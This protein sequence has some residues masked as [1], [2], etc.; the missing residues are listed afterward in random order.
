MLSLGSSAGH[1]RST[2]RW[3]WRRQGAD[4]R[5]EPLGEKPNNGKK[6]EY[7]LRKSPRKGREEI[8]TK[9]LVEKSPRKGREEIHTKLLAVAPPPEGEMSCMERGL[10]SFIIF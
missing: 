9:L 8:H 6:M 2:L 4:Q 10:I 5:A 3:L 7:T 1:G